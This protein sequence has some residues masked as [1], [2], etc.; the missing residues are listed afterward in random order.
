M[1]I[2]IT[3]QQENQLLGRKE[4]Q[5]LVNYTGPTPKREDVVKQIASKTGSKENLVVVKEIKTTY[6]QQVAKVTAYAYASLDDLKKLEAYTEPEQEASQDGSADAAPEGS[7]D[8]KEPADATANQTT[9]DEAA[10]AEPKEDAA[11]EK[12]DS[13]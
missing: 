9:N 11:A 2:E 12:S 4:L 6:G 1:N 8:K 3:A 5:A 13:N 10:P 7:E